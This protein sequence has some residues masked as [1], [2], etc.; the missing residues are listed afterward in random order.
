MGH[1]VIPFVLLIEISSQSNLWW[2]SDERVVCVMI[3]LSSFFENGPSNTEESA[4]TGVSITTNDVINI[5]NEV[6][7]VIKQNKM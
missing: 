2:L 6:F 5:G 7:Q 4:N 1:F 3:D